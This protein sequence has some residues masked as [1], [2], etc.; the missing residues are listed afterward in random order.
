MV[1]RG[2]EAERRVSGFS[3]SKD[4]TDKLLI[5]DG[6]SVKDWRLHDLR[7]TAAHKMAELGTPPHVLGRI[8]NHAPGA[9]LGVTAIYNRYDYLPERRVALDAWGAHLGKLTTPQT[10]IAKS[11]AD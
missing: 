2:D 8:L 7:R 9:T 3:N 4:R 10:A 11:V 6:K 5:D 1:A